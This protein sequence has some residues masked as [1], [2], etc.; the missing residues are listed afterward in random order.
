MA[1]SSLKA[2]ENMFR[3]G[4]AENVNTAGCL[5]EDYSTV[6]KE[7]AEE[8][9][10]ALMVLRNVRE[11]EAH[12]K[13]VV[14]KIMQDIKDAYPMDDLIVARLRHM[15]RDIEMLTVVQRRN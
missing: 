3:E 14:D 1:M 11:L 6:T 7:E 4:A 5:K 12:R 13:K 10:T 15:S 9:A 2:L 8:I